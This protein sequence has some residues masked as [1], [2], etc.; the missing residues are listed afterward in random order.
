MHGLMMKVCHEPRTM[1]N[2]ILSTDLRKKERE[3]VLRGRSGGPVPLHCTGGE[4]PARAV[5]EPSEGEG[6]HTTWGTR[7]GF[8]QQ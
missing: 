6:P 8:L 3:G 1:I 5:S 2:P 7:E 4:K